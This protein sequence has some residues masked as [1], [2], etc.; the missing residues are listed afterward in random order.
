MTKRKPE[1]VAAFMDALEN[2]LKPALKR[3]LEAIRRS[4][5]KIV[6]AIKW[7]APSFMEPTTG[8][9]F[10]TVNIHG[11]KKRADSVLLVLHQGA[12]SKAGGPSAKAIRDPGGLLEWMG[13]DR[14]VVRFADLD[15]VREKERHLQDIVRQ[16]I[17]Q[18]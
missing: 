14:A 13:E 18:L 11:S 3:V 8:V 4:N 7:N 10:A 9:F 12:K 2:P 15:E 16:W 6:E 5:P 1:T 17:K